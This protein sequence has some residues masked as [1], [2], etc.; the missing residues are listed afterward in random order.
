MSDQLFEHAI[1]DW[2]DDGS[3]RTP[4]AAIDAVLLAVRTTPQE[5]DLRTPRRFTFMPA[6]TRLAAVAAIVAV[7]GVAALLLAGGRQNPPPETSPSTAPS[8]PPPAVDTT[9]WVTYTSERYG[10]SIQ[11][12]PQ[13][14]VTTASRDW[15][16]DVDRTS[17]LSP[18][19]DQLVDRQ[20]AYQ[21]GVHGFAVDLPSG[22][23]ADAWIDAFFAGNTGDCPV[24]AANL[25]TIT[26]GSYSGKLADQPACGDSIAFVFH[27][28][29]MYVFTIGRENQLPLF[30]AFLSTV[31]FAP[32]V[33]G[34]IYTGD[35]IPYTSNQ[36][37]FVLGHPPGWSE[38]PATRAWTYRD[39]GKDYLT[40]AADAFRSA[41]GD[42]RVSAWLVPF[43]PVEPE[44]SWE[45]VEAWIEGYCPKTDL[46][47]CGVI[48]AQAEHLCVEIRD[49]H[50]GLLVPFEN[51]VQAFF[52]GGVSE[53][54]GMTVVSVW[55]DER[56][57]ATAKYGGSKR[58]LEAFISTMN[59]WPED[60]RP[61]FQDSVWP[62]P[63][64][65]PS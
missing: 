59:V 34:R 51:G 36:Y 27:E 23:A 10:Y 53:E 50:P 26:V 11:H 42:V 58:L 7:A 21:I 20:A 44:Q 48:H 37:G 38:I 39:D 4:P 13:W 14:E 47:S 8:Q 45:S 2:L 32:G 64:P 60:R 25:P 55:W 41:A 63:T 22:T 17:W 9:G 61:E 57:A 24:L 3:D 19:Q 28:P 35:W 46:Q 33:A 6:S 18:A 12:P 65:A 1:R 30:N 29:R 62:P 16:M 15:A 52:F 54:G 5:R 31:H 56:A 40:P 43:G 49:C